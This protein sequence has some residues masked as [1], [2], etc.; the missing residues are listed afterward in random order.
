MSRSLPFLLLL[1]V[2]ATLHG[3]EISLF[4]SMDATL[5][6]S[7][8][9]SLANGAGDF[10]FTG[11]SGQETEFRRRTLLSFDL[12]QI[13][14]EAVVI[15]AELTLTVGRVSNPASVDFGLH[16]VTTAWTTGASDPDGGE[17][18][19]AEAVEDDAT[20]LHSS[21]PD[22]LW[23]S[24]GGDFEPLATDTIGIGGL[25]QYTYG[26]NGALV[27]DIQAWIAN[28]SDNFGWAII[29]GEDVLQSSKRFSDGLI[30]D[31]SLRSVLQVS[32][33]V[34]EPTF[35]GCWLLILGLAALRRRA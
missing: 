28:P 25:G 22:Q 13:P 15:S 10:L 5:Y 33:Q 21:F 3:E 20:W 16:R 14:A 29:G 26:Q 7:A 4:P 30:E 27:D 31:E 18:G 1:I 32:Y 6:E 17:G 12:G 8:D 34:P 24:P 23:S 2:A 19:G 35:P 9:G 11:R